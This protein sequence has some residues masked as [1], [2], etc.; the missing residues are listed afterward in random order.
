[1]KELTLMKQQRLAHSAWQVV[2]ELMEL[3]D[4]I[5]RIIAQHI[6]RE[7]STERMSGAA[8]QVLNVYFGKD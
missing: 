3:D 2:S 7:H 8:R 1:M 5:A 4:E 6:V